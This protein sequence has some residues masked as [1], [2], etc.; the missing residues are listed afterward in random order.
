MRIFL[1]LFGI[2][3]IFAILSQYKQTDSGNPTVMDRLILL[4]SPQAALNTLS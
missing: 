4:T 2:A 3:K 1:F